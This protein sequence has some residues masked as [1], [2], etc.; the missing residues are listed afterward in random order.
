MASKMDIGN[1]ALGLLGVTEQIA[2]LDSPTND[3]EKQLNLWWD[4]C[5][6]EIL[7]Q[8]DWKFARAGV[9]LAS[10]T[11]P[12]PEYDYAYQL[13]VDCLVARYLWDVDAEQRITDTEY[14]VSG[15]MIC[16]SL[17]EAYLIYTKNLTV[18]GKYPTHF[19]KAL[20]YLLASYMA[21]KFGDRASK[22]EDMLDKYEKA[23]A[24][25]I[26]IDCSQNNYPDTGDDSWLSAGGYS[27][28][29]EIDSD[30]IIWVDA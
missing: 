20:R 1:Q 13:P 7:E 16:T 30:S 9:A 4:D 22:S 24:G 10:T 5:V 14:E 3:A 15:Q 27:S 18:I 28:S 8:H 2:D 12:T 21:P 6:K 23:L 17:E 26:D 19:I 11:A 25:A 29:S